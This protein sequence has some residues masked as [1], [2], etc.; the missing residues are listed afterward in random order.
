MTKDPV[1]PFSIRNLGTHAH[2]EREF[3]ATARNALLHL[4]L[5]L[6]ERRYVLG[7]PALAREFQRICRAKPITYEEH[8]VPQIEAAKEEVQD[9]VENTRW[10]KLYDFCERLYSHLPQEVADYNDH[11]GWTLRASLGEV[12]EYM[13]QELNHLFLEES[14]AFEFRDGVVSRRGRRHTSDLVTRSEVVLGDS[15]LR[16]ARAHYVKALRY[17]RSPTQADPENTV[18]EAVCAVE[19]AARALFPEAK[20]K[21]L[22]DVI[23]AIAGPADGELP[24]PIANTYHGLYGFRSGGAGVGHGGAEGGTATSSIA[25]YTLSVA[26][27]QIILLVDLANARDSDVPF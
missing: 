24:K 1:P 23:N 2:V 5:D 13:S 6:V 11:N 25:E 12:K 9:F 27:S 21:T 22:G 3:P 26:A 18:K 19:A 10:E 20:G 8:F 14:L 17:F 15:R 7:W 16:A 4:L